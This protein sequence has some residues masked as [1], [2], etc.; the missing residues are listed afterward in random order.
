MIFEVVDA[1]FVVDIVVVV[2][3]NHLGG[4]HGLTFTASTGNFLS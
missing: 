3:G 4:H 1:A 2:D